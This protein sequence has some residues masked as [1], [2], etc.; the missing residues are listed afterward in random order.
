MAGQELELSPRHEQAKQLLQRARMKARTNPLRASH[1]ILLLPSAVPQPRSVPHGVPSPAAGFGAH[2]HGVWSR[3]MFAGTRVEPG[4]DP[5]PRTRD[6]PG[7]FTARCLGVTCGKYQ[8]WED[9][10]SQ[11]MGNVFLGERENW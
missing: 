7:L 10:V 2:P 9:G 4:S 6:V 5:L 11:L 3:H 8:W 1:D